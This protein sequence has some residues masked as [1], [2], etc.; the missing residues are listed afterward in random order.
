MNDGSQEMLRLFTEAWSKVFTPRK[1]LYISPA[2][3]DQ[4]PDE[5]ETKT[6]SLV[7]LIKKD[8]FFAK[9][10]EQSCSHYWHYNWSEKQQLE[11]NLTNDKFKKWRKKL[12]KTDNFQN[13][14]ERITSQNSSLPKKY[15]ENLKMFLMEDL[16]FLH[17]KIKNDAKLTFSLLC[18]ISGYSECDLICLLD[19]KIPGVDSLESSF[20]SIFGG[21]ILANPLPKE[22][23]PEEWQRWSFGRFLG[24][25][26]ATVKLKKGGRLIIN[27]EE[28]DHSHQGRLSEFLE[29]F[30]IHISGY[31]E[32]QSDE[33]CYLYVLSMQETDQVFVGSFWDVDSAI[34]VL[35]L[36]KTGNSSNSVRKGK[37]LPKN[38]F[39]H[40]SKLL[41]KENADSLM[42]KYAEHPTRRLSELVL[43]V[44]EVKKSSNFSTKANSVYIGKYT[45]AEKYV[46]VDEINGKNSSYYGLHLNDQVNP[47]FLMKILKSRM[48]NLILDYHSNLNNG[49]LKRK[50]LL[51]IEI[52]LPDLST[53]LNFVDTYVK[54]DELIENLNQ[55]RETVEENPSNNL[56]VQDKIENMLES[57]G[58]LSDAERVKK[59]IA[60]GETKIAE[61]KQTLSLDIK[62]SK[63]EKYIETAAL[64]TIVGFLNSSGG[65]LLIGVSDDGAI[66]G[67]ANEIGQLYTGNSDKFLLHFKNI[68]NSRIGVATNAIVQWR[69]ILVENSELIWVQVEPSDKACYLDNEDFY[70]RANPATDKLTG[71][72]L[73]DYINRRFSTN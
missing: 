61:F 35:D 69:I 7:E 11:W 45:R 40:F 13:I 52:P 9:V 54:I 63:R 19:S 5:A 28:F 6:V 20:N 34:S 59:I 58:L 27:A 41:T 10:L 39:R 47:T 51:E 43:D 62:K 1:K 57:V 56:A 70:V 37:F 72:K 64:K 4:L 66:V 25:L 17:R 22:L 71:P 8:V 33:P 24:V 18:L 26:L 42:Q 36:L 12:T 2:C 16:L 32:F 30:G 60:G 68:F 38:K 50:E 73:V 21:K 23:N 15:R 46:S 65:D 49:M 55:F 48:G 31:M 14:V 29:I 44:S 67:I 53:Q 3:T